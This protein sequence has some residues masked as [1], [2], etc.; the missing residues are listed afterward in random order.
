MLFRS[1]EDDGD[2][3]PESGSENTT[4]SDTS[5]GAVGE[6]VAEGASIGENADDPV[7]SADAAE[8]EE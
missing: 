4:S 7:P 8:N 5:Q 2:A 6:S 1:Y 3:A